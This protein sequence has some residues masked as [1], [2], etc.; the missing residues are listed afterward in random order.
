VSDDEYASTLR[1]L[2]ALRR[3]GMRPGLETIGSLLKEL[4]DPQRAFR[5]IHITGS[6]GKGSTA[7]MTAA[8]LAAGGRRV[9]LFTSPHLIS[10]RERIRVDG[11]M[12]SPERIVELF[13]EVA[14]ASA[15]LERAGRL[16]RSPTFFEYTTAMGF[17]EFAS[18]KVEDAVVEVGLGGRLDSTNVLDA[19]VAVL[20][21]VELEHTD[22]LGPTVSDVAREKA[23][24]FHRGQ[25]AILGRLP[26]TARA[27]V[28]HRA[29][30]AGIPAWHLEEEIR[31]VD[32]SIS[33]RGQ[34]LAV[35]LPHRSL[36]K[37]KIPL[38]GIF[39]PGNVA[40]AVAAVD[41]YALATDRKVPETQIRKGLAR[42]EWRG[43]FERIDRKPDLFVDVAHTPESA[44]A[45]AQ[46][47]AEV[48]PLAPP[49]E[50]AILFGCL[51]E[52]RI[53]DMLEALS[54]LAQTLVAVPVSSGRS[55][56]P[57]EIRRLA[58]GRFPKVVQAGSSAAGLL[59]AR[60]ATGPDGFTLA[61]GSDYL[62][63]ELLRQREPLPNPEPDLSDPGM[64]PIPEAE[65]DAGASVR[66]SP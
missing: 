5:S 62:I 51:A 39:Q 4:G 49:E 17:V 27:E 23:G 57:E 12:V 47:L 1:Q 7:A 35:E 19:P 40:L 46:S 64:G 60:A 13:R 22:I 61:V 21:T 16:D 58:A 18:R 26:P 65:A 25:H 11:R 9:G 14:D 33:E 29:Y 66:R 6:K 50:S 53:A 56:A 41:R 52:K 48:L 31:V 32:R 28:D 38:H 15:G 10:Y 63:G 54:P 2:Y 43:R 34:L 36:T 30:T 59:L 45:L 44:R 24:I 37:L 42:V 55:A 20:T 8:I 3:F